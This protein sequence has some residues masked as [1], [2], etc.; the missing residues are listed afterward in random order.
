MKRLEDEYHLFPAELFK[1]RTEEEAHHE[2]AE[3]V[4]TGGKALKGTCSAESLGVF[5]GYADEHIKHHG[6][7]E[8]SYEAEDKSTG[9]DGFFFHRITPT[10]VYL[11][12]PVR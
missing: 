2:H 3:D 7:A 11:C 5:G 1:D 8:R 4:Y 10:A 12:A 6:V 9:E